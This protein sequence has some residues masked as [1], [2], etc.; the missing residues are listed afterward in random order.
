MNKNQEKIDDLREAQDR[1][2]GALEIVE[3][4]VG[5]D[6]YIKAYFVDHMKI[7][8][9]RDHG[10]LDGSENFDTIIERLENEGDEDEEKMIECLECGEMVSDEDIVTAYGTVCFRCAAELHAETEAMSDAEAEAAKVGS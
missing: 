9:A 8:A 5:D 1:F 4:T 3:N 7:M 10:F 2:L 6:P